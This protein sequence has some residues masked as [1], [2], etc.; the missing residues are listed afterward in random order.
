[1]GADPEGIHRIDSGLACRAERQLYLER[2]CPAMRYPVD[3]ISESLYVLGLLH[4]FLFRNQKGK[5]CFLVIAVKE[6]A[7][8]LVHVFPY[9]KPVG[10]PDVQSL[11][12]IADIHDLCPP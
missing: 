7:E 1:M 2:C 6:I 3:L 10:V 11:D 5:K 8:S 4:K 12:R 9:S